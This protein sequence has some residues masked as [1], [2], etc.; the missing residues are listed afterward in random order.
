M[1]TQFSSARFQRCSENDIM[2]IACSLV[3]PCDF[4]STA[5]MW[6]SRGVYDTKDMAIGH[7][8]SHKALIAHHLD[9]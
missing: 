1:S 3:S 2:A 5:L 9:G 4:G 8:C 6:A 7:T